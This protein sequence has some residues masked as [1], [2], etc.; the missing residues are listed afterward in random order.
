MQ[1]QPL[2]TSSPQPRRWRHRIARRGWLTIIVLILAVLVGGVAAAAKLS[3][4]FVPMAAKVAGMLIGP[5]QHKT[6]GGAGPLVRVQPKQPFSVLVLATESAPAYAGP[7]LTD[8]MMVMSFDPQAKTASVLSVPR[9]LWVDIPGFGQQRINTAL[10]NVGVAGA[11]LTVEQSIGVPI[12]Y[13]AIVNYNTFTKLVDDVGGV[14]VD[15]PYAI[16]DSCYPNVA[17]NQ[18][19]VLHIPAGEQH[20]DGATALEFSRDR[21]AFSDGDIQR[22]RDQQIV[23][24]ALKDALL[25]P[26]NWLKLPQIIG[27]MSNLVNTNIPYADMPTLASEVLQ[28]PKTS[29]QS[30]VLSY[31]S[32]AVTDYTTSGR[33]QVLLPHAGPIKQVVQQTF[34]ALLSQMDQMTVQVENGAATTNP[35]AGEFTAVLQGMGTPTLLAEQAA[36]T[37]QKDNQVFVNT[38]VVHLGRGAPLPTEAVMLGQML[39]AQV[40]P[41]AMPDSQAQIVVVLGSAFPGA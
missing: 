16:D 21:H 4:G 24:F 18:C 32:G 22:Q 19:T 23:L 36:V 5:M 8:S 40:S 12:E 33:A 26:Q 13:Y 31:Q 20:M 6:T 39:G 11:E 37:D 25:Q 10:E 7:Q 14:N 2:V 3:G 9:D 34:P 29:I 1:A 30:G 41:A 28:L 35:L 15:V 38:S 17:E 27:D